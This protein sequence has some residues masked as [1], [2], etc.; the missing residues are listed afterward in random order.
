[1]CCEPNIYFTMV[2]PASHKAGQRPSV[3]STLAVLLCICFL[4][5][6]SSRINRG[7]A[8]AALQVQSSKHSET[9]DRTIA[10]DDETILR[11]V[12]VETKQRILIRAKDKPFWD[13]YY[14]AGNYFSMILDYTR[15]PQPLSLTCKA[16][17]QP[18]KP[19]ATLK[20]LTIATLA[21]EL[22][23]LIA[24]FDDSVLHCDKC[25]RTMFD[26]EYLE[27]CSTFLEKLRKEDIANLQQ[28]RN[29]VSTSK[30]RIKTEFLEFRGSSGKLT[31]HRCM[32]QNSDK[33]TSKGL[34]NNFAVCDLAPDSETQLSIKEKEDHIRGLHAIVDSQ[35]QD[36]A[37]T[38]QIF[39]GM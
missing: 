39:Q 23:D 6:Q 10:G 12:V 27:K 9:A 1:V 3:V 20:N 18:L 29:E 33:Y 4:H 7:A 32:E 14:T 37:Y 22:V 11:C 28:F 8:R 15:D 30:C 13:Y 26:M 5:F 19:A 2:A 34:R 17:R 25:R 38:K 16:Y 35:K 31:L 36:A 24:S 21:E